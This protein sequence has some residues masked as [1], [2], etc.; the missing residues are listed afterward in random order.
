LVT[1]EGAPDTLWLFCGVRTGYILNLG[2]YDKGR[3]V[4]DAAD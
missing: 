4:T 3:I 2:F 1:F